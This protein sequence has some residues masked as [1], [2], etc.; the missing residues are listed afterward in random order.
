MAEKRPKPVFGE[1]GIWVIDPLL[2]QQWLAK[3]KTNRTLR[4][5]D[6]Q[7]WAREM[8]DKQWKVNGETIK[9]DTDGHLIDGQHRLEGCIASKTSFTS[10]VIFG[11]QETEA[12]ETVDIGR[13]RSPGDQLALRGE[14]N[15][16]NLAAA[17]RWFWRFEHGQVMGYTGFASVDRQDRGN[18]PTIHELFTLL[19]NHPNIRKSLSYGTLCY[20]FMT[21]SLGT[22]LHYQCEQK[23]PTLA[24]WFFRTLSSGVDLQETD[25]L[26][27]LRRRL[28]ENRDARAKI[29]HTEV[30]A[31]TIKAWNLHRKNRPC[32][33]L[34]FRSQ[35]AEEQREP[36][37]VIE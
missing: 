12:Q 4:P 2:A 21:K 18:P 25:A 17:L 24:D 27:H 26:W 15:T 10:W 36:F 19:E 33:A 6:V 3:Q 31:L 37:P 32:R 9:F 5:L 16:T 14:T 29:A 23:D 13:K 22:A 34:R 1:S 8:R 28:S 20:R 11:L 7:R 30:A 35:G